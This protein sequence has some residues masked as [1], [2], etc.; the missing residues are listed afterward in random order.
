MGVGK[1][2]E[3]LWHLWKNKLAS[4]PCPIPKLGY[5]D[6]PTLSTP[7]GGAFTF[8]PKGAKRELC[9]I[10][11]FNTHVPPPPR[12]QQLHSIADQG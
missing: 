2:D 12:Q 4:Y 3:F 7:L 9:A 1:L 8:N 10:R 5:F 6:P 11:V